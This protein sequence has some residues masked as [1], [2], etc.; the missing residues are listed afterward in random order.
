[1]VNARVFVEVETQEIFRS[2]DFTSNVY[3]LLIIIK[4]TSISCDLFVAVVGRSPY[5]MANFCQGRSHKFIL[6]GYNFLLHDTTLIYTSSLTTLAAI[7]AQ[8]NFQGLI[9]VGYIYR[10]T[11][12][13]SVPENYFVH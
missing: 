11:L 12:P 5:N 1:M 3:E 9:L 6:G 7:S 4:E 10:Y 2:A 13:K 8:N